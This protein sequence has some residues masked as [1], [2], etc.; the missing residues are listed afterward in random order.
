M[1]LEKAIEILEDIIHYV[2][3]GD[4]PEEHQAVKLGIEALKRI[5]HARHHPYTTTISK[6]P[7]ETPPDESP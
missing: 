7:G 4:P 3:P 2:E 6:L 1:K 5:N